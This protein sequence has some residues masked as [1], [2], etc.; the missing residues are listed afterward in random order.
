MPV[1]VLYQPRKNGQMEAR[2]PTNVSTIKLG[3]RETAGQRT[4]NLVQSDPPRGQHNPDLG[5]ILTSGLSDERLSVLAHKVQADDRSED[6]D[7]PDERE[8]PA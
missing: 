3:S 1:V 6:A 8:G 7:V 2:R 4:H 5:R